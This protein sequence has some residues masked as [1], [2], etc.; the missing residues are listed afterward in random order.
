MQTKTRVKV[1]PA[2]TANITDD[3]INRLRAAGHMARRINTTGIFDPVNKIFRKPKKGESGTSDIISCVNGYF[4]GWEIKKGG[5]T[6]RATQK[7]FQQETETAGGF[8]FIIKGQEDYFYY[9]ELLMNAIK[10]KGLLNG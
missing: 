1:V 4:V 3:V 7:E 6:Q 10:L 5:D 2:T 8:Y 9:Y